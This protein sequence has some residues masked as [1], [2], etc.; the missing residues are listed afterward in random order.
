M[1]AQI[2]NPGHAMKIV[3]ISDIHISP[4]PILDLDP[5][6]NFRACLAHVEQY[7]GD[8]DRIVITGD[9][10]HHGL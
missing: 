10:T 3:H 6:A 4:E 7:Q 1:T 5:V 8:A 2:S 9:L